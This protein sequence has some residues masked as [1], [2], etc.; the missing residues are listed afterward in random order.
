MAEHRIE[1]SESTSHYSTAIPFPASELNDLRDNARL[2]VFFSRDT[3]EQVLRSVT[4]DE[5]IRFLPVLDEKD[6]LMIRVAPFHADDEEV[7]AFSDT[8]WPQFQSEE[9]K[10]A[11]TNMLLGAE[12]LFA[13]VQFNPFELTRM[14]LLTNAEGIMLY[15]TII[16]YSEATYLLDTPDEGDYKYFTFSAIPVTGGV[17]LEGLTSLLPCPPNCGGSGGAYESGRPSIGIIRP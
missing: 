14:L 6:N 10:V 17:P 4:S 13:K 16:D 11:L 9:H 2:S 1:A 15:T 8:E 12:W 5:N 3:L 7:K